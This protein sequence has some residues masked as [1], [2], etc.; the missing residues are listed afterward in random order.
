MAAA[1]CGGTFSAGG[2][3]SPRSETFRIVT[4]AADHREAPD[5]VLRPTVRVLLIDDAER[6]LLFASDSDSGE[7]FW[8][9]PGG[10]IEPG[11]TAEQAA[12]R[13]HREETGLRDLALAGEIG[14]RRHVFSLNGVLH[15]FRERWF[16][17]RV[18]A[19]TIDTSG[20]T[21]LEL[22]T[23][24]AH[25]WWTVAEL[26]QATERLVPQDL[27]Q[28]IRRILHEGVP[29]KPIELGC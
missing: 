12:H 13:E 8:F 25:R 27:A 18:P 16:L 29:P 2:R 3:A 11:E 5:P 22:A 9:P 19:F 26:E 23:I 1:R 15:D 24:P 14:R 17:A 4:H 10:G 6:V 28:L 21:P 7:L 20:F